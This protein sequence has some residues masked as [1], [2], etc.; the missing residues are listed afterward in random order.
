[1]TFSVPCPNCGDRPAGEFSFGGESSKRPA[2]EA[3]MTDLA[4][5]LFFRVNV[6]GV[7]TEWIYHRDGCRRWFIARRDTRSNRFLETYWPGARP[8]DGPPAA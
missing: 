7:Q 8:G 6:A 2:P 3:A 5:Y 4:R 1:V